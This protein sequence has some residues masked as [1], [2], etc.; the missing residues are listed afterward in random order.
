MNDFLFIAFKSL[1]FAIVIFGLTLGAGLLTN[2][3]YVLE[4]VF[5]KEK[6]KIN[7]LFSKKSEDSDR[8]VLYY[9]AR[10]LAICVTAFF[11]LMA[12]KSFI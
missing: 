5:A 2:P 9:F 8:F 6:P 7:L 12:I 11:L 4:R 3:K 1:I 10:L